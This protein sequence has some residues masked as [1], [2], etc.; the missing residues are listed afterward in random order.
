MEIEIKEAQLT[1]KGRVTHED[2]SKMQ[3]NKS[4]GVSKGTFFNLLTEDGQ[5]KIQCVLE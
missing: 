2:V 4:L 3:K 5:Q 1:Y